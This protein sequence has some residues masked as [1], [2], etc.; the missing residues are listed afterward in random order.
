MEKLDPVKY[1]SFYNKL[2]FIM[3]EGKEVLR[4]LSGS[5]IARE[6]GEVVQAFY[7]PTGEAVNIACGILMHIM[8][9]TRVI[10]YMKKQNYAVDIGINKD[11]QFIN[12]DAYIGGMHSP[13]TGMIA[14]CFYK[15]ELIGYTATISHT[16]ETGGIEPGG[17]CPSATEAVHDGIHLPAVKLIDKGVLRRDILNMIF[18]SVRDAR[19]WDVDIKARIAANERVKKRLTELIDE[20]GI[21]FFQSACQQLVIDAEIGIRSKVKE[22]KPGIYKSR[23]YNDTVGA[24]GDK[25]AIIQVEMEITADGNLFIRIPVISP[26]VNG[27]NNSY[28]PAVEASAFYTVLVELGYDLRWN[29]GISNVIHN[30]VPEKSRLNAD[31]FQSVGYATVGIAQVFTNALTDAL[32]RASYLSGKESEVKAGGPVVSCGIWGGIDQYGRRCGNILSQVWPSSGDGARCLKDGI[33]SS[34]QLFNPWSYSADT[35]G[36]EA[37]MPVIH[38]VTKHRPDSGGFGKFRGGTGVKAIDIVHASE[39]IST[40]VIGS[41]GKIP[42]NQGL[43]GGYPSAAIHAD[44]MVNTDFFERAQKGE[45]LPYDFGEVRVMLNGEYIEGPP[46]IPARLSKSGDIILYSSIG[47]GGL[48]DPLERNPEAIKQ[49]IIEGMATV[50]TSRKIYCVSIETETLEIDSDETKH[51]REIEKKNRIKRGIPGGQFIKNLVEK[52]RKKDLPKAALNFL[53]ETMDFSSAFKKEIEKEEKLTI[54]DLKPIGKKNIKKTLYKVTPH[55]NIGITENDKKVTYCSQCGFVF[56]EFEKN[57]KHFCL[58]YEKNPEEIYPTFSSW[59]YGKHYTRP[60]PLQE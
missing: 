9:I 19:A 29:S 31:E 14:T 27:F 17:M 24:A 51:L 44:R 8:N 50:E 46:A 1:E 6:A 54:K 57:F 42:I 41:G 58:I 22:L 34:V 38:W 10:N 4:Y 26:Q 59:T 16:V 30:E 43:F 48:G 28:L 20:V 56:S 32:S 53:E 52:R 39:Q 21:D 23:V 36:E 12:N 5:S 3:N 11:D 49:D 2:S 37:M 60:K 40:Y 47:G 33:D 35:E 13:D 55:I 7:L 25:L 18:R 45:K 15:G